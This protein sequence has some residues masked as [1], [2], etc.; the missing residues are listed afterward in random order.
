MGDVSD[1]DTGKTNTSSRTKR[2]VQ[3]VLL[4]GTAVS[5]CFVPWVLVWAWLRPLPATLQ[6]QADQAV[7]LGFSGVVV[8]V[9]QRNGPPAITTAG[10]HDRERGIPARGDAYFKIASISKLYTAVVITKLVAEGRLSLNGTL[11]EYLP[12]LAGRIEHAGDITLRMLVQHRSGIPNYTDTPDYWAH[13]GETAQKDLELVLDRPADFAPDQRHAYCN[14]NYL[15][16]DRI[17]ERTLGHGRFQAIQERIL[18][19]LHLRRT[20]ASVKDV[21]IGDVMS[22]HHEGHDADLKTDDIGM[23][24]TAADVCAFLRALNT[25]TLLTPE[26]RKIYSSIYEYEHAGWVPGYESFAKYYADLDAVMVTFY[27]TTDRD[28]IKWNLAEILNA[29]FARIIGRERSA[30]DG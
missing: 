26:E 12:E 16:L 5:L 2:V 9:D 24:A 23:V 4:L 25:G 27:S 11:A 10:W 22:G 8:R 15:L 29:R 18:T 30:K 3:L 21:D 7:D 13:P 20:F 19:P 14:T 28:L 17:I 6:E 1:R